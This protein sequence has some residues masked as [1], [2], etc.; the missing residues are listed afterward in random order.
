MPENLLETPKYFLNECSELTELIFSKYFIIAQNNGGKA[1]IISKNEKLTKVILPIF[2]TTVESG[3]YFIYRNDKVKSGP[4]LTEIEAQSAMETF[5]EVEAEVL[6]NTNVK[7]SIMQY[8]SGET[9]VV[10][11]DSMCCGMD[12]AFENCYKILF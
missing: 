9:L 11:K 12:E 8:F 5:E 6:K 7:Y 10:N 3:S 1:Q 2:S 4:Y